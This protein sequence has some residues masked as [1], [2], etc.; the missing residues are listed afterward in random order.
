M[1]SRALAQKRKNRFSVSIMRDDFLL[2]VVCFLRG[3][4]VRVILLKALNIRFHL[5]VLIVVVHFIV[6]LL[7]LVLLAIVVVPLNL[8]RKSPRGLARLLVDARKRDGNTGIEPW[9]MLR[10]SLGSKRKGFAPK[11]SSNAWC[12]SM[13]TAA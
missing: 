11:L 13:P 6:L 3:V 8:L 9:K 10:C 7:V 2:G 4:D 12:E 5:V 1:Y